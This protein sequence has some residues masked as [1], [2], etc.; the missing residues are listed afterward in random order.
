VWTP[1]K[2]SFVLVRAPTPDLAARSL[3]SIPKIQV[4]YFM[5]FNTSEMSKNLKLHKKCYS[6]TH[7]VALWPFPALLSEGLSIQ[8]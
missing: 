1:P 7:E 2:K 6:Q 8:Q 4:T 5:A 3:V